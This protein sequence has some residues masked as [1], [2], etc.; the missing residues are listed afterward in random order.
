MIPLAYY[1]KGE[2]TA[3]RE[4]ANSVRET[5]L[6]SKQDLLSSFQTRK[7][8]VLSKGRE[9]DNMCSALLLLFMGQ[10]G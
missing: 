6:S 10:S 8:I 1:Q 4:R 3:Q 5:P 7:A 9:I 2:R